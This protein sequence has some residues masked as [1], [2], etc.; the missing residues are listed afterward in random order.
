MEKAALAQHRAISRGPRRSCRG[1]WLP[2]W[3]TVG[4]P[5]GC[6]EATPARGTREDQGLHPTLSTL[7]EE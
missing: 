3:A 2:P 4:G 5:P 6:T 1:R 7:L